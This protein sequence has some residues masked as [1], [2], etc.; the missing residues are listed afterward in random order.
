[1]KRAALW[2]AHGRLRSLRFSRVIALGESIH[3]YLDGYSYMELLAI[4][5]SHVAMR[6]PI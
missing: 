4:G 3:A 2:C 5:L 1:M 6:A